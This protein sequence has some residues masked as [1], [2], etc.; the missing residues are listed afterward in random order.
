MMKF[1]RVCFVSDSGNEAIPRPKAAA[2]KRID[3][4]LPATNGCSKLFGM[5]F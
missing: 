1:R 4:T 2:T 5:I 3:R